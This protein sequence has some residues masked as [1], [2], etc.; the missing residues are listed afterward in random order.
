MHL[1]LVIGLCVFY[2]HVSAKIACDSLR[3]FSCCFLSAG[4]VDAQVSPE[5][6]RRLEAVGGSQDFRGAGLAP[7]PSP[8]VCR[9]TQK[10]QL[11]A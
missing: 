3:V 2:V 8:E 4:E 9:P 6:E 1:T 7:T 10:D 5:Y 11:R